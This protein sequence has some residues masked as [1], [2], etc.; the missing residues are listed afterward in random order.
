[1]RGSMFVEFLGLVQARYGLDT[2]D[3]IV[4]RLEGELSTGGAYTAV[5][6]Y[7]H[8]ELLAMAVTLCSL[9]GDHIDDVMAEFA[10]H[11]MG[12]FQRMHG[13]YFEAVEDVF[14][15]LLSVESHIHVDVR[16]LYPDARP[17]VVRG[18][19]QDDGSLHL[20]YSSVRPMAQ[21][22]LCLTRLA[23]EAFKQPLLID[24]LDRDPEGRQIS[25]LLRKAS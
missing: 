3:A 10:A 21:L 19:R 18:E 20:H 4:E 16:K 12:V 6:N 5:G 2:V 1:M 24:V 23:G 9:T 22:A 14:D 8:G 25:M 15:F 7:P 17:P 11:L 13:E